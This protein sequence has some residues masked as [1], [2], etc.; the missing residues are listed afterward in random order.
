MMKQRAF[1]RFS[2]VLTIAAG[3][4]L[5]SCKKTEE[6]ALSEKKPVQVILIEA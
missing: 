2:L 4:L 1:V 5:T 3:V 6:P